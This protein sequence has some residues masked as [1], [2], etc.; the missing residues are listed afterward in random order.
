MDNIFLESQIASGE[1]LMFQCC[2]NM[3]EFTSNLD[4]PSLQRYKEKLIAIENIDPYLLEEADFS[5]CVDDLPD[6]TYPDIVNYLV[7]HP[8]PYSAEDMKAYKSLEAYN[9]VL[10]G[11]V[12]EIGVYKISELKVI[13]GKVRKINVMILNDDA[14]FLR[15]PKLYFFLLLF[16]YCIH[17]D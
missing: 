15:V 8:S 2:G 7:F 12:R 13:R 6:I 10:E 14:Y 17:S 16:R 3:S 9:Q 1:V 11:W 5:T 4:P